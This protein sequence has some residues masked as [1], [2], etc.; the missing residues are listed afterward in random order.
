MSFFR[1]SFPTAKK[2]HFCDWCCFEIRKHE[3]YYYGCGTYDG[4]FSVLKY[5][6]GCHEVVK[7]TN[8]HMQKGGAY[9]LS[10]LEDHFYDNEEDI[11]LNMLKGDKN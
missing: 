2:K 3:T 11:R 5:H 4:E 1:A 9:D 10:E 8:L 6:I 7:A